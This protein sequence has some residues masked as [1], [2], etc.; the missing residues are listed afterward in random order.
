MHRIR[1]LP[2]VVQPRAGYRQCH[3]KPVP[4]AVDRHRGMTM[5]ESREMNERSDVSR[6]DR[7]GHEKG[8]L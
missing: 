2:G 5:K 3:G 6:A 1:L 8:R 4:A 7:A